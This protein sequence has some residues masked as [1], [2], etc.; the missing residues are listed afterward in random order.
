VP[1]SVAIFQYG[2]NLDDDSETLALQMPAEPVAGEGVGDIDVDV[3]TYGDAGGWPVAPDGHG[4]ALERIQLNGFGDDRT[5]W[6]ASLAQNGSPGTLPDLNFDAWQA[7]YFTSTQIADPNVSGRN[8]DPDR[9]GLSNFLEHAHGL[10]PL[11]PD[12]GDA[13]QITLENDGAAGPFLTL[14]YRRNPGAI[15]F[16]F[17]VDT[18]GD[19]PQWIPDAAVPVGSLVINSDG[20]ETRTLRDTATPADA[21]KRFIRL[22]TVEAP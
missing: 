9:D 13:L 5:N 4:P 17:H 10:D 12:A 7:A 15:G 2:G 16:Q 21:E 18:A 8:A 19:L 1:A 20:T 14:R 11:Q 22:R 3:V 6:R